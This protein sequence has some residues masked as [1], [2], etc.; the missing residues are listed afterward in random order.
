MTTPPPA[1]TDNSPAAVAW[2]LPAAVLG[3]LWLVAVACVVLAGVM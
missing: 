2:L 1:D 3:L